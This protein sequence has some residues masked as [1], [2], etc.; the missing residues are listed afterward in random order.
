MYNNYFASIQYK[1]LFKNKKKKK[2]KHQMS[3]VVPV[4]EE[5]Q[6]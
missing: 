2:K 5:R 1:G 3:A 4:T 6:C